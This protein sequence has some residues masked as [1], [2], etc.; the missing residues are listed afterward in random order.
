MGV[1]RFSD[2]CNPI[3]ICIYHLNIAVLEDLGGI[4]GTYP[5]PWEDL[6]SRTP[7]MVP[8]TTIG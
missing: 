8:Y 4:G 6:E 1:Y 5:D 7:I 3:R 2:K